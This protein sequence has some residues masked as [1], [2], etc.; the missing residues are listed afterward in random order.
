[1]GLRTVDARLVL[2][3]QCTSMRNDDIAVRDDKS[4]QISRSASET[5]VAPFPDV[6][7]VHNET[8]PK[9]GGLNYRGYLEQKPQIPISD[10]GGLLGFLL[11]K[12]CIV[13]LRMNKAITD[14]T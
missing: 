12:N 4:K 7:T 10:Y 8:T 14:Y 2:A 5:T 11:E 6:N 3:D 1:M 13:Q 9:A